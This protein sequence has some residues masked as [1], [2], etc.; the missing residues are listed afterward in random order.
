MPGSGMKTTK[1]WDVLICH[2]IK[3]HFGAIV[4]R[5]LVTST[6]V[7]PATA[8][9]DLQAA[10]AETSS[11]PREPRKHIG[12]HRQSSH[13]TLTFSELL[14]DADHARQER[15]TDNRLAVATLLLQSAE[16]LLQH[17]GGSCDWILPYLFFFLRDHFEQP[18]HRLVRHIGI[19]VQ[20]IL[21]Q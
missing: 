2:L 6:R 9:L 20:R 18:I 21:V 19:Q 1:C 8:R 11:G 15:P 3:E 12:M 16:N 17:V 13:E 4:P 7:F 14:V 10:L 5:Q